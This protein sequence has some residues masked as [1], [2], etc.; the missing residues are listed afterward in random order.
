[1]SIEIYAR[2]KGTRVKIFHSFTLPIQNFKLETPENTRCKMKYI[3][4]KKNK[5]KRAC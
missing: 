3:T 2:N 5:K 1:M 4:G